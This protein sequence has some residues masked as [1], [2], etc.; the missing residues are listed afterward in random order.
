MIELPGGRGR[1]WAWER[2]QP[3]YFEG[4][5]ATEVAFG[6]DAGDVKLGWVRERLILSNV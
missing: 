4:N 5:I 2:C 6:R 1:R 3:R